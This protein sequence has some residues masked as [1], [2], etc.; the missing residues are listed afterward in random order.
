MKKGS[1]HENV[2][3]KKQNVPSADGILIC[4]HIAYV[5]AISMVPHFGGRLS[6][7]INDAY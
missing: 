7:V 6:A 4:F 3:K 2:S 1:D 5:A